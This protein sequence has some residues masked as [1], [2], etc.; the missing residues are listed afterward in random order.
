MKLTDLKP[1]FLRFNGDN[2]SEVPTL[3]Q[4]Q[5]VMFRCPVC[6]GG[7]QVMVAFKNRGVLD[8]QGTHAKDGRPTRW[9]VSGTS[10][11]DL[12]LK[13]SVDCTPSDP[14]CWHGFI[15][16]GEVT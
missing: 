11:A 10:L 9:E 14:N 7:H 16:N 15:T 8:H 13:P 4:A 1:W 12:T 2:L 5:G 3:S 6:A